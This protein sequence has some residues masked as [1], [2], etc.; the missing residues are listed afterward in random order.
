MKYIKYFENFDMTEYKIGDIIK[1]KFN[2]EEINAKI[3]KI[4][5]LNSYIINIEK[6]GYYINKSIKISR[7]AI[8]GIV[9]D[10]NDT[11]LSDS[12][13]KMKTEM[14]SNDLVF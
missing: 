7:N 5:A 13:L 1:I 3:I 11:D 6:N 12:Y 9:R 8:I 14:P 10:S 4:P 2:N